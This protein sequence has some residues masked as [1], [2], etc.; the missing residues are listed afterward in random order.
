MIACSCAYQP[1]AEMSKTK[2]LLYAQLGNQSKRA[3][4]PRSVAGD[5]AFLRDD[6]AGI[7]ASGIIER[8]FRVF[9]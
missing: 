5:R 8:A 6:I 4:K 7:D 9:D 3:F 1:R 2:P